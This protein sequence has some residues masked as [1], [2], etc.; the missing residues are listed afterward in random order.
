MKRI[1]FFMITFMLLFSAIGSRDTIASLDRA[2]VHAVGIDTDS[3]GYRVTLQVFRPEN[4]GTDTQL[5]TGKAN[6]FVISA[7]GKTV[8][9]AM[10]LC[11]NRLGE[12]LFIGHDQLIVIGEGVS[13][14]APQQLF[15]Y[16]LK[17]KESYMGVT[18]ACVDGTAEEMLS[19]ELSEG[20]V[21][22]QNILNIINRH[23]ENSETVG[24]DLIDAVNSE[25]KSLVLPLLKL[26]KSSDKK[27]SDDS[28]S[29]EEQGSDPTMTVSAQGA[30]VFV[31]GKERGRLSLDECAGLSLLRCEGKRIIVTLGGKYGSASAA[32]K[33]DSRKRSLDRDGNRFRCRYELE[34]LIQSDQSI[35][36]LFDRSKLVKSCE[37]RIGELCG[38]AVSKLSE[39]GASDL[40]EGSLML[41]SRYPQVWL[42]CG[43]DVVKTEQL[44]DYA[45]KVR[46]SLS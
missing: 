13:L 6:V 21:A 36:A 2:M 30:K 7:K 22:A 34:M 32:V 1:Y 27:S 28:G 12:Y 20:A 16:F 5:D 37:I 44:I 9:E 4:P 25:R 43:G 14:E 41:R 38:S 23:K 26:V 3:S 46:C 10:S 33:K 19:A 11:E 17:S 40:L 45:I 35:E 15:S 18:V 31:G 29:S 8:D 39:V 24:C 42:D